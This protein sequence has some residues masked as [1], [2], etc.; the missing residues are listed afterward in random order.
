MAA[1]PAIQLDASKLE[2][3]QN[4]ELEMMSDMYNRMTGACNRKCIAPKYSEAELSKGESV[5]LDRCVA[6]YLEV[7]ERIGKKLTAMNT[8]EEAVKKILEQ[9]NSS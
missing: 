4:L 9:N 3:V 2:L 5:C 8:D 7:H 1:N 6:K